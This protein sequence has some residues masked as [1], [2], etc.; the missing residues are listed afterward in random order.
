MLL[1]AEGLFSRSG[2]GIGIRAGG[3]DSGFCARAGGV[4]EATAVGLG[5]SEGDAEGVGGGER[6]GLARRL[7]RV[8]RGEEPFFVRFRL[9]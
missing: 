3:G 4:D 1:A 8:G 6:T 9:P 2:E 7:E 5:K